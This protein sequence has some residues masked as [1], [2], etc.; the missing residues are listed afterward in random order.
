MKL[1]TL[2]LIFGLMLSACT[3]QSGL[4]DSAELL[5]QESSDGESSGSSLQNSI[6]SASSFV[7][8]TASPDAMV[9]T[10]VEVKEALGQSAPEYALKTDDLA[11]IDEESALTEDERKLLTLFAQ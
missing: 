8:T 4:D 10:A 11:L 2:S 7:T 9:V 6:Q 1:A 5:I 3:T